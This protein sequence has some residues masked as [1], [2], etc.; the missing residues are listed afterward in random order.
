[1]TLLIDS[2]RRNFGLKA[3]AVVV[4]VVLWFTFNYFSTTRDAY[5]KTLELPLALHAV[6][7]GLVAATPVDHV[8]I[9]LTGP[10][11]DI[12]SVSPADLVA[13][14]DCSGK[15]SGVY[16]LAV[17]IVG[18]DADKVK[19]VSP[20]Y[21]VVRVD[22]FGYRTVPVIARDVEGGT[23]TNASVAPQ[24]IQVA[25]GESAVSQVVAAEVSVP[26]PRSLPA[27]FA[28]EMKPDPV[29]VRMQRV[30]GVNVLGVVRVTGPGQQEPPSK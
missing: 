20:D 22:R 18:R 7:A 4:S 23:L 10:R 29:D 8:T 15:Q 14:A 28:A 30:A 21:A 11:P 25:G 17:S 5:S 16:S 26:E 1:M 13:F 19:T 3:T 6:S 12:D 24:T 9:E 27:G 2:V